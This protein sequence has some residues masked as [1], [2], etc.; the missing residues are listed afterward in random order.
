MK[1]LRIQQLHAIPPYSTMVCK[2]FTSI[3]FVS[4]AHSSFRDAAVYQDQDDTHYQT[5]THPPI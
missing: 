4:L 1:P 5:D 3:P 2:C